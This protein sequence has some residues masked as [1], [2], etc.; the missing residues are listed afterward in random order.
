[1]IPGLPDELIDCDMLDD[2][3][4]ELWND[5]IHELL[6]ESYI[7]RRHENRRTYDAGC[8]GPLC[9]KATREHGRRRAST[10][11]SER[12][13]TID[14]ILEFWYPIA[15]QRIIEVR[16]SILRELTAS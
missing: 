16:A 9:R 7:G 5:L 13:Q 15:A 1:M 2:E 12:Y 8:H 3:L 11:P 4:S 14:A 10:K 6:D